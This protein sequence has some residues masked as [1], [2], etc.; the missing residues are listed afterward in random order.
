[1]AP[2]FYEEWSFFYFHGCFFLVY[3]K[4]EKAQERGYG[5]KYEDKNFG[6]I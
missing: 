3:Y 2:L 5:Q 6:S 1:M 4:V